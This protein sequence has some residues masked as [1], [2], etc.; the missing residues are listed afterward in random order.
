MALELFHNDMSTCSQKVRLALAEKGIEWTGHE[1]DLRAG[2]QHRPDYLKLNAGG[3]VPTIRH[4]GMTVIES[5]VINEYLDDA[6]DGTPLRPADG[7]ARARMRLWTKQL[8]EGVHAA[9]GVLSS[10]IA[11]R[12]QHFENRTRQEVEA[13]IDMIPDPAKRERQRENILKGLESSYFRGAVGRF[14]KLLGDLNAALQN[15]DWLAGSDYSLADIAYTPYM[16]RLEH[17]Q[18]ASM[19]D[20]KPHLAAWVERLQ[21]RPGFKVAVADWFN[22]KYLPLMA[23][24]GAQARPRIEAILAEG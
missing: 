2:D 23:E 11:F 22:P 13:R 15:G 12:F 21:A 18:L 6:F 10:C 19:W 8:D 5:T 3:V 16:V 24:K 20:D 17:L 7:H 1:L 4:D 14:A 9:T